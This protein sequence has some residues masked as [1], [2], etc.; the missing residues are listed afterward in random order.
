VVVTA[1]AWT[2]DLLG[3][4]VS[5]PPLTTTREQVAFF[6]PRTAGAWPAFID[7]RPTT[8][9]GVPAPSGAVKVGEHH[10]GAVTTGDTRSFD[11]DH[12]ALARVVRYVH[13]W[14]PGLDPDPAD[15][16][17]CLYTLTPTEDFI[18]DRVGNVVIGAGFSGHGFK[19]AP[20]IGRLLAGMAAGHPPPGQPFSI[21]RA[22]RRT[23]GPSTHR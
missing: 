20:E 8:C 22:A 10:T 12:D 18:L 5:L 3:R 16:T 9:Y 17:T 13:E 1:G 4:G 6:H 2:V 7:R 21:A 14:L 19:F 15:A 23:I 11:V